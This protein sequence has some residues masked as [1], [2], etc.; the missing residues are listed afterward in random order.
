MNEQFHQ[1]NPSVRTMADYMTLLT[2]LRH[3]ADR[4]QRLALDTDDLRTAA[5]HYAAK[6]HYERNIARIQVALATNPL[7]LAD[8]IITEER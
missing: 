7:W 5:S 6:A 1:S 3:Y 8:V 2:I 4:A